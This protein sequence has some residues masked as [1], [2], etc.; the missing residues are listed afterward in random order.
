MN[1]WTAD[2][3]RDNTVQS[4]TLQANNIRPVIWIEINLLNPFELQL[5]CPCRKHL[6]KSIS[7]RQM[8]DVSW[9][10]ANR[11]TSTLTNAAKLPFCRR[12]L[13]RDCV[14][15]SC[16]HRDGLSIDNGQQRFIDWLLVFFCNRTPA[17]IEVTYNAIT[18]ENGLQWRLC[19]F[20]ARFN[21]AFA[22]AES[23]CIAILQWN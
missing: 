4:W 13:R 9:S 3:K 12:R 2:S 18:I 15:T 16:W 21:V 19:L 20:S 8:I 23:V 14:A 5:E 17:F 7:S 1:T 6:K 22:T 10:V 11:S